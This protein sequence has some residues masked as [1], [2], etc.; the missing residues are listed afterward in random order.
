V[1]VGYTSDL[2]TG[3]AE[4]IAADGLAV[5]RPTG[6]YEPGETGITFSTVPEV[7]DGL[8]CLTSY[9]VEDTG[10]TDAVTAVQVRMRAG[11]DPRA[12]DDLADG[13]FDLLHNRGG[14]SLGPVRVALV[15]R[16]SQAL[17]GQDTHGR[18]ELAANFYFRTTRPGSHLND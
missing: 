7:P 12:L 13:V 15:W 5:Y 3:L 6:A 17:M 2:L 8:I 1:A 18:M 11:T 16:Q 10:L 14:F 9:V 4:L